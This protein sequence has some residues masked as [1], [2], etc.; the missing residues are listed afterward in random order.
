MRGMF[1]VRKRGRPRKRCNHD[2][3]NYLIALSVG[4][5]GMKQRSSVAVGG[6]F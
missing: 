3:E 6:L 5:I 4:G 1:V 2:V